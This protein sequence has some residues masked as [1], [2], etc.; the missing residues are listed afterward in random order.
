M[1]TSTLTPAERMAN[2]LLVFILNDRIR[3]YLELYDPKAL[4]QAVNAV[5]AYDPS[6]LPQAEAD[7]ADEAEPEEVYCPVCNGPGVLLGALGSLV[8]FRCRNCGMDFHQ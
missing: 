7:E 4:E 5:K 8:H 2:A 1:T 3:E 6:R